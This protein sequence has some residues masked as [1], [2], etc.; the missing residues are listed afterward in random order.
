MTEKDARYTGYGDAA[1]TVLER[2]DL[3]ARF[4]EEPGRVTR[5][6]A[7]APMHQVHE[8]LRTWFLA[9]GMTVEIDAVGNLI[10][11]YKSDLPKARKHLL[12]FHLYIVRVA[13][14]YDGLIGGMV[15][16]V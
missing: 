9:L 5:R 15:A 4:S 2:C 14:K 6:F 12:G 7:S 10:G 8:T 3:F 11:R 1:R 16:L 13:R